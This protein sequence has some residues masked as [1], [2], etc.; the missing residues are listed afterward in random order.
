MKHLKDKGH[1]TQNRRSSETSS[2]IFET[3]KNSVLPH[4]FHIYNTTVDM[5]MATMCPCTPEHHRLTHWKYV[6]HC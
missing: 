4:I 6:L 2:R 1:N 5:A 3:Y